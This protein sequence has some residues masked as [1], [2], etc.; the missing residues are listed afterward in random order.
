VLSVPDAMQQPLDEFIRQ[1]F[2]DQLRDPEVLSKALSLLAM[3]AMPAAHAARLVR[4]QYQKNRRDLSRFEDSGWLDK[5]EPG[6]LVTFTRK[7]GEDSA[8][9]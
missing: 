3:Q 9:G 7:K 8:A 1:L 2:S 6:Q 5:S 4:Q